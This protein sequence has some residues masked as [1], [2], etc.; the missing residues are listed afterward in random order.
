MENEIVKN[1]KQIRVC[2]Y[3]YVRREQIRPVMT[4]LLSIHKTHYIAR[5]EEKGETTV[6]LSCAIYMAQV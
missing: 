1:L 3:A 5:M 6:G 2:V 4:L